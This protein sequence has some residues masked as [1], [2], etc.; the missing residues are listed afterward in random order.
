MK[1]KNKQNRD[2]QAL[3]DDFTSTF[4][5]ELMPGILHNF[6]NPLNTIMGRS[7]LLQRRF[8]NSLNKL[9]ETYPDAA[10]ELRDDWERIQ[11]DVRSINKEC[12]SFYELFRDVSGKFYALTCQEKDRINLIQLLEEETRFA[13]FYLEFKHHINKII[14]LD[15]ETV[16][17]KGC[18]NELSL[19][20]WRLLRFAMTRAL[21][22]EEKEFFLETGNDQRNIF[23]CIKYSG[24]AMPGET[25]KVLNHYAQDVNINSQSLK[26]EKGVLQAIRVLKTYSASVHFF[27]KDHLNIISVAIPVSG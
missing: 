6:A 14:Q 26:I 17:L 10:E 9:R 3:E 12:D 5:H 8:N 25:L 1:T 2:L 20:F 19:V 7:R 22:S 24:K 27:T 21:A 16:D 4:I 18:K 13:N 23:I 11:N 15:K